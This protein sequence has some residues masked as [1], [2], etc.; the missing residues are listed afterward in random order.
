M[1]TYDRVIVWRV[2]QRCNMNCLFCSYAYGVN[3]KRDDADANEIIRVCNV[4]KQHIKQNDKK[5]LISWIGGEPF[6]YADIFRLSEIC[7]S[8]GIDISTTTNGLLLHTNEIRQRLI[9]NF[10]EIV[11][12]LDG[13]SACH[14]RIRQNE[15]AFVKTSNAIS[16][17]CKQKAVCK[18]DLSVKVNTI[19]LRENIDY[20]QEFCNYLI[21][22]GVNALTFNQLG[23][24]DRPE[25]YE[26]NRLLPEQVEKFAQNF[27]KIKHNCNMKGL[28]IHGGK[29]YIERIRASTKNKKIPEESCQPGEWFWFINENGFISPCSYT[30]YEY[31]LPTTALQN[32][33]D[34]DGSKEFFRKAQKESR[35][36][37]CDDCHCT[38]N[39]DKFC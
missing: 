16:D 6:L 15:G 27:A 39:N 33:S 36:N 19:L 17:L 32:T 3:R 20:F 37:W 7:K 22:L 35:S 21:N 10:S 18:S 9:D 25:F 31:K 14:D 12:S 11:F 8:Y 38:Q 24:F 28:K 34:L 30:S 13:F 29:L 2:T 1:K 5:I 4:L 26:Q 23:G